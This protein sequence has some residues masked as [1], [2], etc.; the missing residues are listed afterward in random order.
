V[1]RA[2]ACV[3]GLLTPD[4]DDFT[5]RSSHPAYHADRREF[6]RL[7]TEH[8]RRHPEQCLMLLTGDIHVGAVLRMAADAAVRPFLQIVASP[9]T[10]RESRLV[11]RLSAMSVRLGRS[12]ARGS[13]GTGLTAEVVGP[14]HRRPNAGLLQ[15][16]AL[17]D[18]LE[19]RASLWGQRRGT[20]VC[21]FRTD[22]ESVPRHPRAR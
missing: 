2:L 15:V 21:L 22:A 1:P 12:T 7:L 19:V 5:D 18:R 17:G 6:V 16:R 20:P 11:T 13:D 4:G 10:M 14:I 9:L 3:G 8:R